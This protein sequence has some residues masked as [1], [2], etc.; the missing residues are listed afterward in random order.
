MSAR[1][2]VSPLPGWVTKLVSIHFFLFPCFFLGLVYQR[3][4]F[5][6]F[7]IPSSVVVITRVT[8][9]LQ[10]YDQTDIHRL[11]IRCLCPIWIGR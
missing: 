7:L 5:P 6:L 8:L 1:Y 10:L 11:T 3:N 9:W 2:V 4:F